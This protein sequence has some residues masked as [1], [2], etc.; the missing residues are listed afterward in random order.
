MSRR[1]REN[2]NKKEAVKSAA[3]IGASALIPVAGIVIAPTLAIKK[4]LPLVKELL[5]KKKAD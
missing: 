4:G 5:G 3:L 2:K 1:T